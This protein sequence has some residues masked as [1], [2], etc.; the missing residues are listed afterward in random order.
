MLIAGTLM[1][2][3]RR[4]KLSDFCAIHSY[5]MQKEE[6]YFSR[7]LIVMR[8]RQVRSK[9]ATFIIYLGTESPNM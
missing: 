2:T 4:V 1:T 6:F 5:K 8:M 7:T 9:I 3:C